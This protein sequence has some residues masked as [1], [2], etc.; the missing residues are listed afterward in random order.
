MFRFP[1]LVSSS[2]CSCPNSE[3]PGPIVDGRYRGRGAPELDVFEAE[4]DKSTN[5]GHVV[6]QSA[7]FAP[8]SAD[9]NFYNVCGLRRFS[10]VAKD[11]AEHS[12]PT[13]HL[14]HHHLATERLSWKRGSTI[15]FHRIQ[16]SE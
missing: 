2:S 11:R 3:H 5:L 14:Q 6:S 13:R 1:D 7:Q 8:F 16:T 10:S 4:I 9:Y 15:S 12:G